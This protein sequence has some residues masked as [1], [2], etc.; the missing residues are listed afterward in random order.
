M[1]G[2]KC[3][4]ESH[5]WTDTGEYW[6]WT[7]KLGDTITWHALMTQQLKTVLDNQTIMNEKGQCNYVAWESKEKK[8]TKRTSN[9]SYTVLNFL[10]K[11]CTATSWC[12]IVQMVYVSIL[13]HKSFVI[14]QVCVILF[15]HPHY[16]YTLCW[17]NIFRSSC[18][19]LC[20]NIPDD[21]CM[22]TN[23]FSGNKCTVMVQMT[24]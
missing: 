6:S 13:L 21:G 20:M 5:L 17:C 15:S 7:C 18:R 3:Q 19:Q 12:T 23:M 10:S 8:N 1:Q 24:G 4:D 22:M 14:F 16:H 2:S 11:F 9:V